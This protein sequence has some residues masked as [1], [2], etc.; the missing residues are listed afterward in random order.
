MTS[1]RVLLDSHTLYWVL[2]DLLELSPRARKLVASDDADV[3]VSP[4]SFYELMFKAGRGRLD[5]AMLRVADATRAASFRISSPPERDWMAAA[6][7]DWTHGDP[8]DRLLLAQAE[9]GGMA[10]VSRDV[11]FDDVSDVRVW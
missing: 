5:S 1:R 3:R 6:A 7:R 8:F 11:I 4:A 10:L 9:G 2:R